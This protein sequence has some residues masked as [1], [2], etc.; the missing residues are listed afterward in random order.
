MLRFG[1]HVLSFS[2]ISSVTWSMDR[3]AL[4]LFYLPSVV[5]LY[6]NALNMF[7]NA[8]L[9]PISQLH[10]V[11]A[12]ALS[13]LS[14]SPAALRE[15]YKATLSALAFFV[16]PAAAIM[17]VTAQDVAVILLG[18]RWRQS[19]LLL[20]IMVSWGI[21]AFIEQSQGWLHVSSGRADRWKNWGIVTFV[22]RAAAILAGLPFG[23]EGV[24]IAL[25]VAGWLIAFPSVS[26]AGSPL[27]IG[28][29]LALRAVHGPLLGATIAC[30]AGWWLRAAFLDDFTSVLRIVLLSL[31]CGSIYLLIVMG[32]FRIVEP[33]RIASKLLQ[34]FR[35]HLPR[36]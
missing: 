19:G 2:I 12:A 6:Q 31:F 26:Y 7:E 29:G 9:A 8:L 27:G 11:G 36:R 22:V 4:G 23:A 3:I 30:A 15:K 18:E 10:N 25:V 14:S 21:V 34:D 17:S 20:S 1:M 35:S 5:G 32:L 24:A 16:M 13:K 33:I 28:A